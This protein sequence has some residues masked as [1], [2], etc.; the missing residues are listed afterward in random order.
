[1]KQLT[2]Q[3]RNILKSERSKILRQTKKK[4]KQLCVD[5]NLNDDII[6]RKAFAK[7]SRMFVNSSFVFL[8]DDE[9]TEYQL[10]A[11]QLRLDYKIDYKEDRFIV[12]VEDLG[13]DVIRSIIVE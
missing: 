10:V 13:W 4:F 3:I 9:L 5:Y 8:N 6:E 11:E 12:N 2:S 1:M 7:L